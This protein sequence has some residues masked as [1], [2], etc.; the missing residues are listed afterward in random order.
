[1]FADRSSFEEQ[2][3]WIF[4]AIAVGVY[5]AYAV[6]VLNRR[7]GVPLTEVAYETTLL[8]AIGAAIALGIVLRIVLAVVSGEGAD[9]RDQRDREIERVS[10]HIG[11]SF[12]VVGGVGV[13][14]L[15]LAEADHFWIA[16]AM[17]LAFVLS[18]VVSSAAKVVAYRRG[19]QSW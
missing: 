4:G 10:D 7:D 5:G 1:M 3:A 16:N 11:Q 2:W 13:L 17:Y 12:L 8:W 15:A 19:F 9:Q 18:A 14:G 6:V